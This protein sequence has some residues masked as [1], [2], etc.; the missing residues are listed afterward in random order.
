MVDD[1]PDPCLF[2]IEEAYSEFTLEDKPLVTT[3]NM[4]PEKPLVQSA[5]GL[6]QEGSILSYQQLVLT[7]R[8]IKLHDAPSTPPLPLDGVNLAPS[9]C[10]F[11]CSEEELLHLQSLNTTLDMV[12]KTE[13]AI[14]DQSWH[15]LRKPRITASRFWEVCHVRGLSSAESLAELIIRGN[16]QTAEMSR[17]A[18]MESEV[19]VEYSKLTNVNYSPCGLIIHPDALCLGV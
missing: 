19:K 2:R 11:V 7:S 6:V 10:V 14:R 18:E 3:M 12:Q 4:S 1:L 15:Q 8:Y 5:F 9:T 17:G 16:R 13:E